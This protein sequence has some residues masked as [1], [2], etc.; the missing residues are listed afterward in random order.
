MR[1]KD[2]NYFEEEVKGSFGGRGIGA[3]SIYQM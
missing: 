2:Y 1:K 3:A